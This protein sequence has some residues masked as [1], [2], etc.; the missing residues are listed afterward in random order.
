MVVGGL[1]NAFASFKTAAS[2]FNYLS[3]EVSK[4]KSWKPDSPPLAELNL[5]HFDVLSIM[6]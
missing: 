6:S 1:K 3:K 2:I 4:L 5:K